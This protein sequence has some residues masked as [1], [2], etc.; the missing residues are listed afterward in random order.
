MKKYIRIYATLLFALSNIY[1]VGYG[2]Y[3][4]IIAM[5]NSGLILRYIAMFLLFIGVISGLVYILEV[6]DDSEVQ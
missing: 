2:Y 3:H 6:S 5:F 1:F 4:G